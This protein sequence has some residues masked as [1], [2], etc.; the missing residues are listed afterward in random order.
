MAKYLRT[1]LNDLGIQQHGPTT[2]YENNAASIV[3]ANNNK[4]NSKTLHIDF[5][6]FTLQEWVAY[7]EVKLACIQGIVNLAD[8]LAT[9]L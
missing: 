8:A 7:S 6:Y 4:P 9:A 2:I 5:N 1:V 3:M